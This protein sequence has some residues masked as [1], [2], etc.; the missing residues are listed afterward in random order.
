MMKMKCMVCLG[1]NDGCLLASESDDIYHDGRVA[2]E[3]EGRLEVRYDN[4]L[5]VKFRGGEAVVRLNTM[6]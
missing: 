1:G 5:A 3:D 6:K 4:R 2:M